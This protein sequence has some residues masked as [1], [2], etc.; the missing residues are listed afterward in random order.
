MKITTRI[1]LMA[2]ILMLQVGCGEQTSDQHL[3]HARQHIVDADYESASIELKNALQ[4]NASSAE[5]RWLLGTLYLDSGDPASAEKE[6]T[7]ALELGWNPNDTQPRLATALLAQ[8]EYARVDAIRYENLDSAPAAQVLAARALSALAQGEPEAANRYIQLALGKLPDSSDVKMAQARILAAQGNL[9]AA[10]PVVEDILVNDATNVAAM[11]L[12]AD[13]LRL[14]GNSDGA[15]LAYDR[16]LELDDNFNARFQ[17]ALINL[18]RNDLNAAQRDTTAILEAHPHHPTSNY[19]QGMIHFQNKAYPEAI[20]ALSLAQPATQIFPMIPFYLGSSHLLVGNLDQAG[21]FASRFHSFAPHDPMGRKLLAT[22]RLQQGKPGEVQKLVRPILDRNPD[23][24]DALNLM[25]SALMRDGRSDEGL[26]MLAHISRLQPDSPAAQIK[27]GAGLMITGQDEAA[28]RHFETAVDLDEKY[29]QADILL[30]MNYL[31]KKDYQA[32]IDAAKA[33]GS[34][35]PRSTTPHNVLG[36]VYLSANRPDDASRSFNKALSI[37]PGDPAANHA[38]ATMALN[39]GDL[40]T[41]RSHYQTVLEDHPDSLP[42]LIQMAR[43]DAREQNKEALVMHLE[44]AI[45]AHADALEPKL[46][47]ARYYAATGKPEK[48]SPI[49]ATVSEAQ[50]DTPQVLQLQALAQIS[51]QDHAEASYTLEQLMEVTQETASSHHLL[52]VAA[53]GSGDQAKA[54]EELKKAIALDPDYLPSL[55]TLARIAAT[56]QNQRD[57]EAYLARLTELKPNASE[58]LRLRSLDALSKGDLESALDYSGRAFKAK[59]STQTLLEL[60]KARQLAGEPDDA[61]KL[62]QDWLEKSPED[63]A[64]RMALAS[65]LNTEERDDEASTHYLQIVELDPDNVIALNNL[66]WQLR[67]TD[68]VKASEYSRRAVELAPNQPEVLDTLA[69]IEY[70]NGDN[71]RAIKTILRALKGAPNNP[72]MIY[73]RAMIEVALGNTSNA[74]DMLE[75][76]LTGES[77]NFSEKAEAQA[78]LNYLKG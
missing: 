73:H 4:K 47:L 16:L 62:L 33:Y 59:A 54:R 18:Q 37:A 77:Q 69:V 56:E 26:E 17:R 53:N 34:R 67:L 31:H 23:D 24:I 1:M 50:R 48:I 44:R 25:A 74:I 63:I 46:M 40:E 76:I 11:G 43:L 36:K 75:P 6:L 14:L 9:N 78:L 38:L 64:A 41:A 8:R 60:A 32:A 13:I 45:T 10:L 3:A 21:E 68:P 65:M 19:L 5:A 27:L 51:A 49:L 58:V 61:T 7:R 66:A 52:A 71:E 57:F 29:Q 30:V 15:L 22:I 35:H 72:N 42:T 28:A 55:V 12:K 39:K 70:L 2:A 20:T